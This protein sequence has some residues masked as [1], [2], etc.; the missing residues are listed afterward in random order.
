MIFSGRASSARNSGSFRKNCKESGEDDR[1][2]RAAAP[3]RARASTWRTRHAKIFATVQTVQVEFKSSLFLLI[4][5]TALESEPPLNPQINA[6]E[7][8]LIF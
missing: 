4:T 5:S 7:H 8:F 6:P 3:R 2:E 1:I